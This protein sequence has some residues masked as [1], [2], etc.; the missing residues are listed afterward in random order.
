MLLRATI[1]LL[2]NGKAHPILGGRFLGFDGLAASTL[3]AALVSGQSDQPMVTSI[4]TGA[5]TRE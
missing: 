4:H 1:T 3:D 5:P 2:D